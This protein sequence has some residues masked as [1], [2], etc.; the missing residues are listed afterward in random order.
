MLDIDI[1]TRRDKWRSILIAA[2]AYSAFFLASLYLV[3]MAMTDLER[4]SY[5]P[6]QTERQ[7]RHE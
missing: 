2:L 4:D 6:Q 3:D 5:P 7:K 1:E